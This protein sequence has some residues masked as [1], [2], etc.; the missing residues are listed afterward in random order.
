MMTCCEIHLIS[1]SITH[2][3]LISY[4]YSNTCTK[5]MKKFQV[6]NLNKLFFLHRINNKIHSEISRSSQKTLRQDWNSMP[7]LVCLRNTT[8]RPAKESKYKC[9]FS[10]LFF[11]V[12][13]F[14]KLSLSLYKT[15]P[16]DQFLQKS[17]W[18][19][20]NEESNP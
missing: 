12:N 20:K 10:P 4:L 11:I 6:S 8:E 13:N 18:S 1:I 17:K 16:H 2:R 7:E 15:L 14:S 9:Y 3:F 19:P 5:F